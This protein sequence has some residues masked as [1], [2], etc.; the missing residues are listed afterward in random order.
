MTKLIQHPLTILLATILVIVFFI[1]LESS[2]NKTQVS[3]QNIQ[4]L[5]KEVSQISEEI[6][7]LQDK[8]EQTNTQQFQEKIVRNE[9]LLQKPNE[10]VLQIPQSAL[11]ETEI[12]EHTQEKQTPLQQWKTL[13]L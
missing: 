9:L 10:F 2:S 5:E 4:V 8:I 7:E 13:L 3:S 12:K 6:L 11:D 1:S